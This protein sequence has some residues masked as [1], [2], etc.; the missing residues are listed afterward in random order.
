MNGEYDGVSSNIARCFL[1][2]TRGGKKYIA[3]NMTL[4][5][6]YATGV[7]ISSATQNLG[8]SCL[9]E[10][11]HH[12]RFPDQMPH[13]SNPPLCIRFLLAVYFFY[14]FSLAALLMHDVHVGLPRSGFMSVAALFWQT[15]P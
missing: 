12:V 3:L 13:T 8:K 15:H 9:E 14:L 2:L 11:V 5:E 1:V 6:A 7:V 10:I 4:K